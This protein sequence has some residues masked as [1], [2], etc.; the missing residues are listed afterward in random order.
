MGAA[1]PCLRGGRPPRHPPPIARP[2]PPRLNVEAQ[3]S[4]PLPNEYEWARSPNFP[5]IMGRRQRRQ[6]RCTTLRS[7][8]VALAILGR[9]RLAILA[10]RRFPVRRQPRRRLPSL[11]SHSDV[12]LYIADL[13]HHE[14]SVYYQSNLFARRCSPAKP[15]PATAARPRPAT[16]NHAQGNLLAADARPSP[17]LMAEGAAPDTS[18][19]LGPVQLDG[20]ITFS[21]RLVDSVFDA[22][23]VRVYYRTREKWGK[24][25]SGH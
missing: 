14:E 9:R 6:R 18:G 5:S 7:G 2:P 23:G 22:T 13:N 8:A 1:L 3:P 19:H 10:R 25:S 11:L 12:P 15:W 16:S 20:R 17:A 21:Q 24:A 4:H